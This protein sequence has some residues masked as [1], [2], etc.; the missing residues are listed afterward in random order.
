MP[1]MYIQPWPATQITQTDTHAAGTHRQH[2]GLILLLSLA[3]QDGGLLVRIYICTYVQCRSPQHLGSL[4][5]PSRCPWAPVS[6]VAGTWRH[7][8]AALQ[9]LSS[10]S[11][12]RTFQSRLELPWFPRSQPIL[13]STLKTHARSSGLRS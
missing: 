2:S 10:C 5:L 3:E 13:V 7:N 9:P 12:A 4:S 8:P 1:H 11:L 6:P